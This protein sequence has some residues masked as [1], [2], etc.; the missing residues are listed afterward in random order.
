MVLR[1]AANGT[2]ISDIL[3]I[4]AGDWSMSLP[5]WHRH[6]QSRADGAI[7]RQDSITTPPARSPAAVTSLSTATIPR[8]DNARDIA[9]RLSSPVSSAWRCFAEISSI[10]PPAVA[11]AGAMTIHDHIS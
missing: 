4:L 2:A 10:R 6:R 3:P 7:A 11:M 1:A 5:D 9:K 8:A